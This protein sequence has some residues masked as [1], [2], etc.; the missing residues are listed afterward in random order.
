[1]LVLP[2]VPMA[3]DSD[4]NTR[5]SSTTS[6]WQWAKIR[7]RPAGPKARAKRLDSVWDPH[8]P[9]SLTV[10]YLGGGEAW[11]EVG[12]RGRTIK[13]PGHRAVLDVLSEVWGRTP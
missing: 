2:I 11:V 6:E 13:V 1:M 3:T 5:S 10:R 9:V 4:S 8:T 7:K 12:A